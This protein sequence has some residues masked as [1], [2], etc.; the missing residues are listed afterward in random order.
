MIRRKMITVL[1]LS[2]VLLSAS[3]AAAVKDSVTVKD[4]HRVVVVEYDEDG[5]HNTRVSI[6]SPSLQQQTEPGEYIVDG[7]TKEAAPALPNIGRDKD[8]KDKISETAHEAN[9]VKDEASEKVK[10]MVLE[11]AHG[12]KEKVAETAYPIK[13]TVD[14]AIG[15]AK[16]AVV[17]TGQDVK[18]RAKESI[19]KAKEEAQRA[20]N[21]FKTGANKLFDGFKYITS[22]E[23]LNIVMGLGNLL[24][25]ATAYGMSVWVTFISSYVLAEHLPRQQFGMVQS[26]IYPVYFRAMA[27]SIGL[28]S[29]GHFMWHRKRSISCWP[30]MFQS[31]N[32]LSSLFMVLVNAM[33]FEPKATKVMFERMKMEKEEGRGRPDFLAEGRRTTETPSVADPAAKISRKGDFV[34]EG[35]RTTETP[36]VADPA[37]KISRKGPL[38]APAAAPIGSEE[39]VIKSRMARLNERLKKINTNSSVLNILTLMA[40][41]WHL[42]YLGQRLTVTC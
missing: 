35:R 21:K 24:G 39:E 4:G 7:T 28:A 20:T 13:G 14:D 17:Q 22:M 5:Q 26:K 9:K 6:S 30:E 42:V 40:L 32:L 33:Y 29:L 8:A 25:L 23:A 1:A 18:E 31:F 15:K 41:T 11:T 36:S 38:P 19:D 34:A 10:D 3:P 2:L 12:T 16:G 37:A 27:Y